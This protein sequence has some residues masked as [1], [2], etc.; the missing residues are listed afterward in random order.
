MH[1]LEPCC[2]WIW[3]TNGALSSGHNF[4]SLHSL[5]CWSRFWTF[6][7]K[8][9]SLACTGRDSAVMATTGISALEAEATEW[10]CWSS[11]ACHG[12]C[13]SQR[14]KLGWCASGGGM[15]C[16]DRGGEEVL[17]RKGTT[18]IL[19][20]LLL[21]RATSM[22]FPG[23]VVRFHFVEHPFFFQPSFTLNPLCSL[24]WRVSLEKVVTC[25]DFLK[26]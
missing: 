8:C 5:K 25:T 4:D 6:C 23:R 14:E 3:C 9:C 26:D 12:T 15:C 22:L 1:R 13:S 16:A 20:S 11:A 10:D 2:F 21:E 19:S 18:S 17:K 24:F 7:H